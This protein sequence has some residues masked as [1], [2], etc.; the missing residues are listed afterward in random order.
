MILSVVVPVYNVQAYLRQCIDSI[1]GQTF[2]EI[3]IILVDDGSTDESA[4]ICDE[5]AEADPRVKV[6]HQKNTGLVGARKKGVELSSSTYITFVDS[7]DFI[8][9][10]SYNRAVDSM[11][12][13][14]DVICFGITRYYENEKAP[15]AEHSLF[16]EKIYQKTDM[17]QKIVPYMI[18]NEKRG[19]FGLDPS[20]CIKIIK[21]ELLTK[22]YKLLKEQN[23]Y[24]AE[25]SAIIF[26][27]IYMANSMEVRYDSFYNHRRRKD[28]TCR[29]YFQDK[30]FL[31]K[32]YIV[33][34]HLAD[35][36]NDSPALIKQIEQFFMYSVNLR[37]R[38]YGEDYE[39]T[40]HLF[41]FDRIE[42]GKRIVLYGAGKL[43]KTY[44]HQL[45]QISYCEVVL[46][47]DK[48]YQKFKNYGV[49]AVEEINKVTYDK[50][51]VAIES[52]DVAQAVRNYLLEKGVQDSDIILA[53]CLKN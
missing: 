49:S 35:F 10:E 32:L 37:K 47:V 27:V 1:L 4:V 16:D 17:M 51:V 29:P 28:E 46:W 21:R 13:G 18:W 45:L 30:D 52:A 2:Q 34:K 42:K 33:Y 22:S 39:K 8:E 20:L 12:E 48:N 31:K 11:K 9:K 3:E 53:C 23:F 15:K 19:G 26:P 36:F 5:Y 6:F 41:P 50:I 44:Y 43:G 7:D 14:I 38:A 40:E 25:D 24:Y